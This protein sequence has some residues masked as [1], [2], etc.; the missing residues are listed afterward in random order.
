LVVALALVAGTRSMPM[1]LAAAPERA[2]F[3]Y[4]ATDG[5]TYPYLIG[6]DSY[7]WVRK[8]EN[9]LAHGTPC[10]VETADG[11]RDRLRHAPVGSAMPYASSLHID[12]IAWLHRVLAWFDPTR[13]I[14]ASAFWVQVIV[15]TLGVVPAWL[16]GRQLGGVWAG[17]V[18]ALLVGMSPAFFDRSLGADNDV[19]NVVL[20]LSAAAAALRALE[21]ERRW[22]RLAWTGGAACLLAIH[23]AI[24]RGWI[25]GFAVLVA[26]ILGATLWEGIRAQRRGGRAALVAATAPPILVV[27]ALVACTLVLTTAGAHVL[28]HRAASSEARS[29]DPLRKT[30]FPDDLH[31][32]GELR[33][34]AFAEVQQRLGGPLVVLGALVGLVV[35]MLPIDGRK[36]VAASAAALVVAV[37]LGAALY[38]SV[39]AQ[40]WLLLAVAPVGLAYAGGV[41]RIV[42]LVERRVRR[43]AAGWIAL[44][45]LAM[46]AGLCAYDGF[47]RARGT[48]P[49]MTVAWWDSLRAI[50][51]SAPPDAIVNAPWPYGYWIEY[52][53]RRGVNA[54][55]SSLLTHAP[56]WMGK[57]LV[58]SNPRRALGLLRML[59]CGSDAWG[60]PEARFGAFDR[61]RA[62]GADDLAAHDLVLELAKLDRPAAEHLLED[63]GIPAA[64]RDEILQATHC[65]PPP[66]YLLLSDTQARQPAIRRPGT[67]DPRRAAIAQRLRSM[68]EAEAIATAVAEL[69]IP[70]AQAR[71]LQAAAR[72]LRT[73]EEVDQFIAPTPGYF[74]L[75]LPCRRDS[76]GTLACDTNVRSREGVVLERF[77]YPQA[78]DA[79]GRGVLRL[80]Q[81]DRTTERPPDAL[82]VADADGV[83]DLTGASAD[84]NGWGVLVDTVGSR[85]MFGPPYLIQSMLTRLVWLGRSLPGFERVGDRRAN[86]ERVLT[87]RLTWPP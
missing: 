68:P 32:V 72:R 57:A 55:G 82:V 16:V 38:M 7:S 1:W 41:G 5:T 53:A 44:A 86:G 49:D 43:R 69:G 45:A 50:E 79:F 8:A 74:T 18:A 28:S 33:S 76:A 2:A 64:A 81:G 6:M 22:G 15:G 19:W 75:W 29:P 63:R 84:P 34:L 4:K 12:A 10:D 59:D 85:V 73:D 13:P 9:L 37:W 66:G 87:W 26:G 80:R 71:E 21:D 54:D 23:A 20:P 27:V 39:G 65:T 58:T 11:C 61:L 14:D 60:E 48:L 62:A 83:R 46:P 3:G 52:V 70:E 67:W 42:A 51:Q 35:L 36:S 77:T 30:V 47:I 40:R 17:F 78:A 25:F 31:D 56:Y 24:W